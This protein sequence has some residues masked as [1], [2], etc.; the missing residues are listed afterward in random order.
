MA[1]FHALAALPVHAL[2][3]GG[4]QLMQ[5]VHVDDIATTII[6]CLKSDSEVHLTLPLVGP[7]PISF[8]HLLEQLRQRLGKPPAL[9]FSLSGGM[10]QR[11]VF[12]G[13]WLGDPP[14]NAE[15]IAMLRQG[16]AADAKPIHHFLL[17]G[18]DIN[19]KFLSFVLELLEK[20]G[21]YHLVWNFR[22]ILHCAVEFNGD[23]P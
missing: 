16:N 11:S 21:E 9:T 17:A 13:K 1:L 18:N 2:I 19:F 8:K 3:D 14:F 10:A 23:L 7:E 5:P 12:M 6:Q 15:N 4:R 22:A 20:N